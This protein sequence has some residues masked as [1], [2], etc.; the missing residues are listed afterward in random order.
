MPRE[1]WWMKHRP[2]SLNSFIFQNEDQERKIKKFIK[3]KNIPHLLL[4]GA[5]GSGKTTLAKIL[6]NELVDKE[7]QESDVLT[8][9]GSLDGKI[10][11]IRTK[12]INH[13]NSIPMG[14]IK[15]ILIDEADGLSPSA[16]DSLRGILEKYDENARVIFT[17]NYINK[18]TPELRSRFS[19]FKFVNLNE[20]K[21]L[22]YCIDILDEEGVDIENPDNIKALKKLSKLF[23]HDFR[24]LI[25]ALDNAREGD[26][27]Y[28]DSVSDESLTEKIEIIDLLNKDNWMRV[29]EIVAE[30]FPD[31][32]LVE[33]YRFLYDYLEDIEK[34][35][36]DVV[37]WKKGIIVI[38][39]HMYR[40]ESH[41]DQ[42][43]NFAS[44]IIRLSEI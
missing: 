33:I 2:D 5:K 40:H 31:E 19:E 25:T 1:L 8:I 38:S 12:V 14:D 35:S 28:A 9:N 4:Y 41:P 10:E 43:I 21:I 18:L 11:N 26:K 16:Q 7:N 3:E 37:K 36:K 20:E 39:D 15:I 17:A 30:N 22:E 44:C 6:I 23:S 34:F 13:A 42:E 27:I 32:E 29:R 24:K